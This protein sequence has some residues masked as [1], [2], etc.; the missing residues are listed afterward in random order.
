MEKQYANM[1]TIVGIIL[2]FCFGYLLWA[3]YENYVVLFLFFFGAALTDFIDG[4]LARS[5]KIESKIGGDMDRFRDKLLVL[6]I[7]LF[8]YNKGFNM[9][10]NLFSDLAGGLTLLIVVIEIMICSSWIYGIKKRMDTQAHR[11]GKIK[12]FLYVVVL[13]AWFFE[14][15][16]ERYL[17]TEY[18]FAL[19][20]S[21]IILLAFSAYFAIRSF[22]GYVDRF[23]KAKNGT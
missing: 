19:D 9:A 1:I 21:I 18:R 6:P 7:F 8:L 16:S 13:A 17:N 15:I 5:R 11:A 14:R 22:Y 4:R 23:L 2:S 20:L 3:G 10:N 12:M